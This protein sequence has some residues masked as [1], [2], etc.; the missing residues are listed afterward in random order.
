VHPDI[1][2][3]LRLTGPDRSTT[4]DLVQGRWLASASNPAT[5]RLQG[6]CGIERQRSALDPPRHRTLDG[7]R[8]REAGEEPAQHPRG[9][10]HVVLVHHLII[11]GTWVAPAGHVPF[12][13]SEAERLVG[14]MLGARRRRGRRLHRSHPPEV[15]ATARQVHV[16]IP[17]R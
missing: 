12:G 9:V 14:A 8:R 13:S 5:V 15:S 10:G 2:F 11:T 4:I 16:A 6:C 3:A 17:A 7:R 1:A